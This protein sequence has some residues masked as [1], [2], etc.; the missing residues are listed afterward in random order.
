MLLFSHSVISD[1]LHPYGL[2]HARLPCPSPSSG[3]VQIHVHWIG[4]VIQPSHPLSPP[5]PILNL[6]QHQSPFPWIGSLHQVAKYWSFRISL[7]S[8]YSGLISYRMD[9]FDLFAVQGILKSLFQH[10][11][12][13]TSILQLCLSS[14]SHIP[15]RLLGKP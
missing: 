12:L 3:I 4:D 9:W 7:S 15:T 10:H 14:N 2:Q 6:S 1:S 8:E 11:N 13:K 5:S